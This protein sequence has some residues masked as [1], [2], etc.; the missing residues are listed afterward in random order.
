MGRLSQPNVGAAILAIGVLAIAVAAATAPVGA[1]L[2][3]E[4][5]E[6]GE[7]YVT[8]EVSDGSTV[9]LEY[10]HSVEKS[11]VYDEYR[12]DGETLVN[13]RMEFESYGWGLPARVNVTNVNG[14]LVYEP[15]EPI[16]VLDEL[17]V[18][19]GRIADHTLIVDDRRYDLV[20]VTDGNDV[21]L[22]IERRSLLEM[23]Q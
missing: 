9:A 18:S 22:H 17:S 11:R 21:R 7:R 10:T 3:V 6:T 15:D 16:T 19:P 2:V 8:A 5:I 23:I 20:A 12:V 13:T 14:T 1:V 4:D